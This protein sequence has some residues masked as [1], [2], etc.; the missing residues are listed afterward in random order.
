[1]NEELEVDH[2]LL[3]MQCYKNEGLGQTETNESFADDSHNLTLFTVD[4]LTEL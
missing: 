4:A 3:P 1:M 2:N